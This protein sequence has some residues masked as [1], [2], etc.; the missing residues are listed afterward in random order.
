MLPGNRVSLFDD[1]AGPP[2][3]ASS[4]RGLILALDLRHHTARVARQYR[5]PAGG[6]VANSEGS[7][8]TLPGGNLFVGFGSTPF[9]SEFSPSGA[10][11]FDA[12]LPTDDGSY[13]EFTFPWSATPTTRPKAVAKLATG[14]ACRGVRELERRHH[15]GSLAG[16]RGQRQRIAKARGVGREPEL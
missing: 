10:L 6:P 14:G 9:F 16:A 3:K 1:E 15:S 12:H 13:R 11:P 4:S 8:Q 2:I 7:F 5:R